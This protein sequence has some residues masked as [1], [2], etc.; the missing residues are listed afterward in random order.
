MELKINVEEIV[1]T[2][3]VLRANNLL[4]LSEE[5]FGT[6]LNLQVQGFGPTASAAPRRQKEG[7]EGPKDYWSAVKREV[8]SLFCTKNKKYAALRK[9]IAANKTAATSFV[10]SAISAAV[11]SVLGAPIAM[12]APLVGLLLIG[13]ATVGVNAW[14]SV[15]R[16]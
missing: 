2:V 10:F 9:Q 12:L 16:G 1:A 4:K 14:C 7:S 3:P 13:I 8:H 6:L 15:H 5:D 11:A